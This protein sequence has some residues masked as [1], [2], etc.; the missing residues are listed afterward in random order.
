LRLFAARMRASAVPPSNN[1]LNRSAN[2]AAFIR[3]TW[4]IDTL[5]ARPVN[6]GVRHLSAVSIW[7]NGKPY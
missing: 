7:I 2:S 4:M 1:S 3:K 6:S 5:I